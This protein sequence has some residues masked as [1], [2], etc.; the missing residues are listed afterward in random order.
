MFIWIAFLV[1]TGIVTIWLLFRNPK[2]EPAGSHQPS[3]RDARGI[4]RA[5][6]RAERHPNPVNHVPQVMISRAQG[7]IAVRC[8]ECGRPYKRPHTTDCKSRGVVVIHDRS[9]RQEGEKI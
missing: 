5:K 8:A 2:E 1:L 3:R 7:K 6:E 4:R 9:G